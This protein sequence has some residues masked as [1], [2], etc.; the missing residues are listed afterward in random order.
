MVRR[1]THLIPLLAV[2]CVLHPGGWRV[3]P[4][5]GKA[6]VV[7]LPVPH[8]PRNQAEPLLARGESAAIVT[9]LRDGAGKRLGAR[10]WEAA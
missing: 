10:F 7:V 4:T 5:W 3:N 2:T 1:S 6:M 9:V 8:A